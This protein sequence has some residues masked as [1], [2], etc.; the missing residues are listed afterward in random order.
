MPYARQGL[1]QQVANPAPSAAGGSGIIFVI[2]GGIRT[3]YRQY[4]TAMGATYICDVT[5]G[6]KDYRVGVTRNVANKTVTLPAASSGREIDVEDEVADAATNPITIAVPVG[7]SLNGTVN[8][9][10]LINVDRGGLSFWS[11]GTNWFYR[12]A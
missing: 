6:G 8:G 5:G 3:Q 7:V 10:V 12:V 2:S 9:T 11:D 1:G 4:T